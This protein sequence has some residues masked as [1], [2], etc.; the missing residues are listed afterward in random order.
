[1][2][3]TKM[4]ER[5]RPLMETRS[6]L[7]WRPKVKILFRQNIKIENKI[8]KRK[9]IFRESL[10]MSQKNELCRIERGIEETGLFT[11]QWHPP[12]SPCTLYQPVLPS[13]WPLFFFKKKEKEIRPNAFSSSFSPAAIWDDVILFHL[14][15]LSFLD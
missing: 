15:V 14:V 13:R 10:L 1:M 4:S 3:I 8:N 11:Q 2:A 5:A 7:E 6:P 12:I 9:N